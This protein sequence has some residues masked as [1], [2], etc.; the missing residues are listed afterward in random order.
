IG[1]GMK[2]VRIVAG[3]GIS[4]AISDVTLHGNHRLPSSPIVLL[5]AARDQQTVNRRDPARKLPR[6]IRFRHRSPARQVFAK[7]GP[8]R[9]KKS[10]AEDQWSC[11]RFAG[12][13]Q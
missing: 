3:S 7:L 1:R 4:F 6:Y 12:I 5:V 8:S 10:F 11:V 13:A 9:P 2:L